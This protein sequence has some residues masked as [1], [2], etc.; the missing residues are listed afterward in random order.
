MMLN[1]MTERVP[2]PNIVSIKPGNF[3]EIYSLFFCHWYARVAIR[4]KSGMFGICHDYKIFDSI[5]RTNTV[6]M[7]DSFVG[8]KKPSYMFFGNK[9]VFANIALFVAKRVSGL[10]L[11]IISLKGLISSTFPSWIFRANTF[12][13]MRFHFGDS[14][15]RVFRTLFHN[16]Y[17]NIRVFKVQVQIC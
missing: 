11:L 7:M 12:T 1:K 16:I 5:I 2:F 15:G 10:L 17:Y 4:V 6:Y 3:I 8:K 14:F 13:F 9:S